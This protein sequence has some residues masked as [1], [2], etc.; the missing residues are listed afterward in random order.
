MSPRL[1]AEDRRSA[2]L[3]AAIPIFAT[4]GLNGAR[5]GDIARAAGISEALLYKHFAS[6]DE[7]YAALENHCVDAVRVATH[8]FEDRQPGTE[9]FILAT[10]VVLHAI[11]LGIGDPASHEHTKRLIVSSL[12]SNG[13]FARAFLEK[14]IAPWM[15][16]FTKSLDAARAAGDLEDDGESAEVGVWFL[17]H[18]ATSLHLFSLPAKPVIDYP[19]SRERL[20]DRAIVFVLRGMGFKRSAIDRHYSAERLKALFDAEAAGRHVGSGS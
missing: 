12:L 7:L 4:M 10:A 13:D 2:I 1:S 18:L 5:T 17:H 11:D 14:Q 16:F 6:K 15:D 8:L 19:M 9:T 3:D 20:A